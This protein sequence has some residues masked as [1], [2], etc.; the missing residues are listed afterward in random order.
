MPT[1]YTAGIVE[2]STK[3][4]KDFAKQCIRAF[5]FHMRD[6]KWGTSYY[7][8]KLNTYHFDILIEK[9]KKLKIIK[10]WTDA[11][12][13]VDRVKSLLEDKR[14]YLEGIS[15]TS[16]L[17]TRLEKLLKSAENYNPP[18]EKHQGI[19]GFMIEQL[20]ATIDSECQ[21]SFYE[22]KLEAVKIEL[23]NLNPEVLRI[24]QIQELEKDILYHH[25]EV[26]EEVKRITDSHKWCDEFLN[27][28]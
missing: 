17:H 26:L 12:F 19:K 7:P 2:G 14:R 24:T 5:T 13:K 3:T 8:R 23:A 11:D 18:T 25:T 28:L 21:C 20:R 6:E 4:F 22:E 15:K 10:K 1:D 27:S 16:I 9:V